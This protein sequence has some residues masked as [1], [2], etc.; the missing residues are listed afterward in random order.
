MEEV[1]AND[2]NRFFTVT[3]YLQSVQDTCYNNCVVDF[4][5]KDIGAMEKECAKACIG[6]HMHIYEEMVKK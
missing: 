6:K 4:Q 3:S 2:A 5:N 1:Q